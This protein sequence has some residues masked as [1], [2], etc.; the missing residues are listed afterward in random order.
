MQ[1]WISDFLDVGCNVA[2]AAFLSDVI[3]SRLEQVI[4]PNRACF[5]SEVVVRPACTLTTTSMLRSGLLLVI[6]SQSFFLARLL[7]IAGRQ[8]YIGL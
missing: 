2:E 6:A 1:C 5:A 3:N 7:W 4:T 8:W